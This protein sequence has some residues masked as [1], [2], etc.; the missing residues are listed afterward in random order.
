MSSNKKN[1]TIEQST[2]TTIAFRKVINKDT[3]ENILE[4]YYK[5]QDCFD[6]NFSFKSFLNFLK[7]AGKFIC[8]ISL[9]IKNFS[10]K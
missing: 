6:L 10:L 8:F 7:S 3:F 5:N 4:I 1:K 2:F 9:L